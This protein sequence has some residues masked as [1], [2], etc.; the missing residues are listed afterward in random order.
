MVMKK[1]FLV[2][3]RLFKRHLARFFTILAIV[4]VSVGF[5]SGVGEAETLLHKKSNQVY[6]SQNLSDLYLKS[7]KTSGFSAEELENILK[8]KF[9]INSLCYLM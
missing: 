1:S 2:T 8:N 7:R 3:L 5:M 6:F 4:F 9:T